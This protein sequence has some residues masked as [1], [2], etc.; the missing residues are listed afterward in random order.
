MSS[1]DDNIFDT[2]SRCSV[3]DPIKTIKDEISQEPELIFLSRMSK[4]STKKKAA[5]KSKKNSVL[6]LDEYSDSEQ[7][8]KETKKLKRKPQTDQDI[9]E[10]DEISE[11]PQK[12]KKKKGSDIL[13]TDIFASDVPI[14]KTKKAKKAKAEKEVKPKRKK[15]LPWKDFQV[16]DGCKLLLEEKYMM[17]ITEYGQNGLCDIVGI[18]IGY[19][20]LALV[21]VRK[22]SGSWKVTHMA[23][24]TVIK[25]D[26]SLIFCQ[27]QILDL[28]LKTKDFSWLEKASK[29]NIEG[30]MQI[31]P[32]ARCLSFGIRAYF[33]TQFSVLN[34]N[35]DVY[36]VNPDSKYKVAANNCEH[37][38]ENPIRE[39]KLAGEQG[40]KQRKQLA[41]EDFECWSKTNE[42]KS[43]SSFIRFGI[44]N[45]HQ[46][47][48]FADSFFIAIFR[49]YIVSK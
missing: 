4:S 37:C 24:V 13:D 10:V 34:R 21:G 23:M 3:D 49:E 27:E 17:Y 45:K 40:R 25:D 22:V 44:D 36:F 31:N 41:V 47:H 6:K 26:K 28:F 16:P 35:P 9:F 12:K 7:Q 42:L 43:V 5:S 19:T 38:A 8:N 18:D 2:E 11:K 46:I 33:Y 32:P 1:D 48:D 15:K 29:I 30:Q 14:N 39:F 20:H